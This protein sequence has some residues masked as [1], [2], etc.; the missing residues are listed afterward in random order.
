MACH[1][2]RSIC[3]L[4]S[5]VTAIGTVSVL[6]HAGIRAW[7]VMKQVLLL[8]KGRREDF[9]SRAEHRRNWVSHCGE[10]WE[11]M[12]RLDMKRR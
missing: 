4:P 5:Y 2:D 1:F 6:K 3:P 9:L 7:I 10:D 8:A 11:S 12:V